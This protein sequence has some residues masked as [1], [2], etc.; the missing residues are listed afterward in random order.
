M[1]TKRK[2][3]TLEYLINDILDHD[4]PLESVHKFLWNRTRS[5]RQDFTFQ[6]IS[7][8]AEIALAIDCFE[9]IARFHILCL[10]RFS[11]PNVGR[12][13]F[14]EQQEYEQLSKTLTSLME[15]YDDSRIQGLSCPNEPEFRAYHIISRM[16]EQDVEQQ[17][18][19]WPANIFE[20]PKVQIALHLYSAAQV[21]ARY[22]TRS[23]VSQG[24][25][26]RYW[27]T[28][29]SPTVTY[30]MGALAGMHAFSVRI[31]ATDS[32]LA[33]YRTRQKTFDWS[34]KDLCEPLGLSTAE[35][36]AQYCNSKKLDV[37]TRDDGSLSLALD[38]TSTFDSGQTYKHP[39]SFVN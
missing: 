23:D 24:F 31:S 19:T 29:K 26:T 15:F 1:F 11:L 33:A 21:T 20:D 16:R 35:E 38:F 36:V 34:L 27:A 30:L 22:S 17:A 39:C 4:Q 8:S 7:D 5:I 28:I 10:H 37:E 18:Q 2:Q 14:V 6:N 32:L 9:Y 12:T 13:D 3:T 25:H